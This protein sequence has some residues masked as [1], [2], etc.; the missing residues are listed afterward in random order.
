M[1]ELNTHCQ[2][3]EDI[4]HDVQAGMFESLEDEAHELHDDI[5]NRKLN[6][7]FYSVWL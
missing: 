5:D 6:D 7:V 4:E 3:E 2:R 1:I